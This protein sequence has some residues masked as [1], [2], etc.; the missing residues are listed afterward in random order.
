MRPETFSLLV[1]CALAIE[2]LSELAH[3]KANQRRLREA[4]FSLVETQPRFQVMFLLHTGWFLALLFES[5]LFPHSV[6]TG[7][8]ICALS[9]LIVAQLLRI[10]TYSSLGTHWNVSIMAPLAS[11]HRSNSISLFVAKG[12]YRFIRHPNY[13]AIMLEFVAVPLLIGAPVTLILFSLLNIG[14]LTQRI[15]EEERYLFSRPG[16]LELMGGKPRFLPFSNW[17]ATRRLSL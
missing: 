14:V 4:G 5:H 7:T 16:Y 15:R 3:S 11:E 12:P 10:W 9:L 17:S 1:I 2:R 13:V 8:M 6:G